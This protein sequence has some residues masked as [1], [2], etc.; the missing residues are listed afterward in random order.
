MIYRQ[1]TTQDIDN[2]CALF[3]AAIKKMDDNGIPQW[4][5]VYPARADFAEDIR[6]GNLFVVEDSMDMAIATDIAEDNNGTANATEIT[7][8]N[9]EGKSSD[10]IAVYVINQFFDEDYDK[11]EWDF[12]KQSS[13]IIHRFCV[14]PKYQNKGLAKIILNHIENQSREMGYKAIRLDAFTL[15]P[16]ALRLYYNNGYEERG[17]ADW[18]MGRFV[19]MEKTL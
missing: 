15:N 13:C 17:Y 11:C 7:V 10:L 2:I 8:D 1:G 3:K 5:E 18:R 12:D 16:Y 4:D 19:L 9:S 14:L 6:L